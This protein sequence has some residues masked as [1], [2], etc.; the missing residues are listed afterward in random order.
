MKILTVKSYRLVTVISL[1]CIDNTAT[2][3]LV[4]FIA[5]VVTF[6][7][8]YVFSKVRRLKDCV[9]FMFIM[10]LFMQICNREYG[11]FYLLALII[12]IAAFSIS[13]VIFFLFSK[14]T[15]SNVSLLSITVLQ[16]IKVKIL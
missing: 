3:I 1:K 13:A 10:N 16:I 11:T 5:N 7:V 2:C 6:L 14:E 12:M 9:D 15:N 8:F 4:T